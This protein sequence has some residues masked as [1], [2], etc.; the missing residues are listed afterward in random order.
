MFQL[1][2]AVALSLVSLYLISVALL[3]SVALRSSVALL[4]CF[5]FHLITFCHFIVSSASAEGKSLVSVGIDEFHSI[6]I[7]D[8][9][10]GEKL[11]KT[12]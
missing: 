1:T 10:K 7:W 2:S 6:V 8:W 9:K 4:V 3:F 11:A 12:R 5:C